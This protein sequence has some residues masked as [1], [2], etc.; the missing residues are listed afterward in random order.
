MHFACKFY[1]KF[2]TTASRVQRQKVQLLH[3]ALKSG[4]GQAGLNP[5]LTQTLNPLEPLAMFFAAKRWQWQ[6]IA[7]LQ[8]YLKGPQKG[9]CRRVEIGFGFGWDRGFP[10]TKDPGIPAPPE[11]QIAKIR[12]SVLVFRLPSNCVLFLSFSF[13]FTLF[14]MQCNGNVNAP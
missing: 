8:K 12:S 4:M 9:S 1:K 11:G 5:S 7:Q 14:C 2:N 3:N 13:F 10:Q 6:K